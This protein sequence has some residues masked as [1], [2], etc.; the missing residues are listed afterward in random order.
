MVKTSCDKQNHLVVTDTMILAKVKKLPNHIRH[1]LKLMSHPPLGIQGKDST[2]NA[3][4]IVS[5]VKVIYTSS[6]AKAKTAEGGE[7][8]SSGTAAVPAPRPKRT[9]SIGIFFRK[10]RRLS[11]LTLIVG[12]KVKCG[13]GQRA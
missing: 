11:S 7:A 4:L 8:G 9:G 13:R 5:P 3:R 12:S 10:V 2:G 6:P 1:L